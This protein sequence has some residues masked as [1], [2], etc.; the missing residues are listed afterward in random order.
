MRRYLSEIPDITP[1]E[2]AE[3]KA[4]VKAGNHPYSNPAHI[5]DDAG[6]ELPFIYKF[7]RVSTS[8]TEF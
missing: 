2:K 8:C 4:W 6:R 5:A 1:K 3:L 7:R